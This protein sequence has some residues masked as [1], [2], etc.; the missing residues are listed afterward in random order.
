MKLN[1]LGRRLRRLSRRIIDRTGVPTRR[2][3][4]AL[5]SAA[6]A[7]G[8][9]FHVLIAP[10]GAGNIGDQAMVEAFVASADR[11]VVVVTRHDEDFVLPADLHDRA[12]FVALPRLLYGDGPEHD[13]DVRS[14]GALLEGAATVSI[15]GADIMDGIYSLRPS[16]RRATIAAVAAGRGF[17][18]SV[19][20]FSW[21]AAAPAP[22]RKALRLAGAAGTRLLLRDPASAARVRDL[23]VRGVVETADI[24]FTDDRLADDLPVAL[25]D[26]S[27]PYAL[28]NASGLIARSVDQAVEYAPVIAELRD[29][30][31]HVVLLPHVLRS[32][33]DDLA[34]CRAVAE[35]VGPEGVTLVESMLG[36]AEIRR[37]AT[38]A[39]VVV[40]GRMH[41]AVMSLGQGVP[42]VTLASQGKVEGLMRL[43]EWPELCVPPRIGMGVGLR[44]IVRRALDDPESRVRVDRGAHRARELARSNIERVGQG[45]HG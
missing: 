22:A 6:G 14:L 9:G 2:F 43:F 44:D 1:N 32:S 12:R 38:K 25:K 42:A 23:G 3:A 45:G 24:V 40:T 39:S 30:G 18:T 34:A 31:I 13:R 11:P 19:I 5:S 35:A 41:L 8:D 37:L 21:N 33:A 28:I 26:L 7:P 36:P 29:R 20:G 4:T 10:P 15:V 16:V 17:D 27:E